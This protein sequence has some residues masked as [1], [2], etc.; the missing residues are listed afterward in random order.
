M[1]A[2]PGM[3]ERFRADVPQGEVRTFAKSGHFIYHEEPTTYAAAVSA[4]VH[5]NRSRVRPA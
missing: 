4:F 1:V 5:S 3:I 2:A